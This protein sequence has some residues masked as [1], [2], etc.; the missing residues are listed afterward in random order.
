MI[1]FAIF[2]IRRRNSYDLPRAILGLVV[3]S[4]CYL[5]FF[6]APSDEKGFWPHAHSRYITEREGESQTLRSTELGNTDST[7]NVSWHG[8]MGRQTSQALDALEAGRGDQ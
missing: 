6:P 3:A 4:V 7:A 5:Q 8:Q 2:Y 1:I